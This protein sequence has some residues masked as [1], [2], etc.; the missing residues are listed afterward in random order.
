MIFGYYYR[1]KPR[2]FRVIP[3]CRSIFDLVVGVLVR[4][5]RCMGTARK[6]VEIK[7][8]DSSEFGDQYLGILSTF[9]QGN[10][11]SLP[12]GERYLTWW[13]GWMSGI[14]VDAAY[15]DLTGTNGY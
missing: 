4:D 2:G 12:C 5:K 6:Q 9:C 11:W 10:S 3:L 14:R 13:S 8:H 15:L 7:A 1:S